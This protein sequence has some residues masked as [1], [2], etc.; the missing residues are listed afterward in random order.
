MCP[1]AGYQKEDFQPSVN[2]GFEYFAR[3]LNAPYF[4]LVLHRC[5]ACGNQHFFHPKNRIQTDEK[6]A[7]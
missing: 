7:N 5:Q 2:Q 4:F 1:K 3:V 6:M